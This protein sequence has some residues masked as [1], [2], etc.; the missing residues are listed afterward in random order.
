M[1][2][3]KRSADDISSF[4]SKAPRLEDRVASLD[5]RFE[6]VA[7]RDVTASFAVREPAPAA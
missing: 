5:V 7:A 6:P 1:E 2:P 4:F 3:K